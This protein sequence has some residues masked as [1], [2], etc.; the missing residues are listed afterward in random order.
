MSLVITE[1]DIAMFDELV[2]VQDIKFYFRHCQEIF[3]LW[4]ELMN[5][6]KI[7]LIIEQAIVK[8]NENLFKFVDTIQLYLDIMIMLGEHFQSDVQ[9]ASFNDILTQTDSS[10]LNRAI[11]L[12]EHLN[13]YKEKVLGD[14]STFFKEMIFVISISQL[15]VINEH[16]FT[17][18]LIRF[19]KHIYPQK[20]SFIGESTYIE[21][22]EWGRE[23]AI[24]KYDFQS[25][26]QQ[27]VYILCIFVL[28]QYFDTDLTYH[29]FNWSNIAIQLKFN[30]YTLKELAKEFAK[31]IIKGVE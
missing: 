24:I 26:E 18:D 7:N 8:G 23:Q 17:T 13:N 10:E 30:N 6:D 27:I 22:I 12:S 3:P 21:L 28:G 19:L 1:K 2:K 11:Q 25:P 9:Y 20:V 5:E 4:V 14:D 16:N 31:I 15:P 29:W